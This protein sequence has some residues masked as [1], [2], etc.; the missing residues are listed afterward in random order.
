MA[1][2]CEQVRFHRSGGAIG[3][4]EDILAVIGGLVDVA[5]VFWWLSL[6]DGP[7]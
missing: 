1:C 6:L 3:L 2:D 7:G 5:F 4:A